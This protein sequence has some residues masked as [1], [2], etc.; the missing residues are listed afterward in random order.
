MKSEQE[1]YDLSIC[2]GSL[3]L[4]ERT[5][6]GSQGRSE[7]N[8][9]VSWLSPNCPKVS[10]PPFSTLLSVQDADQQELMDSWLVGSQLD[11]ASRAHVQRIK[12]RKKSKVRI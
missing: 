5:I 11:S 3:W 7:K 4:L 9:E 12:R 1:C 10:S 6:K 8:S 2:K